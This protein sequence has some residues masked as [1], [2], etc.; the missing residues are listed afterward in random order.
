MPYLII[1]GEKKLVTA[2]IIYGM[3]DHPGLVQ[4]F[5]WQKFDTPPGFPELEKFLEFWRA[6]IEGP[7]RSVNV[8]E[9]HRALP[10][11]FRH[12]RSGNELRLH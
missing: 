7:L 12:F 3:P 6:N 10:N 8:K 4:A 5:I 9:S 1:P 2:E 11:H